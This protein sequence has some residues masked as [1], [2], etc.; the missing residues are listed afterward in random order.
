MVDENIPLARDPF[1]TVFQKAPNGSQLVQDLFH[2]QHVCKS[3][4]EKFAV[5]TSGEDLILQ[6]GRGSCDSGMAL[7]GKPSIFSGYNLNIANN[8]YIC[9]WFM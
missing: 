5:K 6:R 1:S 9:F 7:N 3:S 8:D 4:L 2:P